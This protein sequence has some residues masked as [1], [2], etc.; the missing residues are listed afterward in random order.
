MRKIYWNW[1]AVRNSKICKNQLRNVLYNSLK[2][3]ESIKILLQHK[4]LLRRY[5][6][7]PLIYY[8]LLFSLKPHCAI[9]PIN[10]LYTSRFPRLSPVQSD[11]EKLFQVIYRLAYKLSDLL[12]FSA[13]QYPLGWEEKNRRVSVANSLRLF[14]QFFMRSRWTWFSSQIV[15][16]IYY[17]HGSHQQK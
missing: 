13:K 14:L 5:F 12:R 9:P 3:H 4:L 8:F 7:N 11:I 16:Y 17:A 6:F 15:T 1:I 10:R 2:Q